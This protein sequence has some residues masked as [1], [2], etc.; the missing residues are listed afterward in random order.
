MGVIYKSIL[1]YYDNRFLVLIPRFLF[2][3]PHFPVCFWSN[4][5][6]V[7]YENMIMQI[8]N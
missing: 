7:R 8:A 3:I 1:T 4:I 2:F 6:F 5:T